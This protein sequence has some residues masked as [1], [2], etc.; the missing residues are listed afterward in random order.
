MEK[1]KS[2]TL[3]TQHSPTIKHMKRENM[4]KIDDEF[5]ITTQGQMIVIT[6]EDLKELYQR[7]LHQKMDELWKGR[8]TRHRRSPGTTTISSRR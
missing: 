3:P 4:C 1:Q 6:E 8:G 2:H 7:I 5:F